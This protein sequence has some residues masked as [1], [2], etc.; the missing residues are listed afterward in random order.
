MCWAWKRATPPIPSTVSEHAPA[1][2]SCVPESC[3]VCLHTPPSPF[4]DSPA[5]CTL[6]VY[7]LAFTLRLPLLLSTLPLHFLVRLASAFNFPSQRIVVS[8]YQGKTCLLLHQPAC[9]DPPYTL[10]DA[11]PPA[12]CSPT[13]L[14]PLTAF[15]CQARRPHCALCKRPISVC[16]SSRSVLICSALLVVPFIRFCTITIGLRSTAPH[17]CTLVLNVGIIATIQY[18]LWIIFTTPCGLSPAFVLLVPSLF[19]TPAC[20][21]CPV[22]PRICVYKPLRLASSKA[23]NIWSSSLSASTCVPPSLLSLISCR[24]RPLTSRINAS[25]DPCVLL[26]LVS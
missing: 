7:C 5:L 21:T 23:G 3:G 9:A 8:P 26:S 1:I 16:P 25:C 19:L 2:L 6:H 14:A 17:P 4:V 24:N 11:S 13:R 10:A 18:T 12:G 20:S 15:A 22:P